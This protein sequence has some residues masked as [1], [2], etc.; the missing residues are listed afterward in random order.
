MLLDAFK[1]P[2][3]R[4]ACGQ[5][6]SL[7]VNLRGELFVWG[8]GSQGQLGLGRIVDAYVP[9][10]V[11]NMTGVFDVSAGDDYSACLVAPHIGGGTSAESPADP[12]YAE[13]GDLWTWGSCEAGKLGHE[14][15]SSGFCVAPKKV[16]MSVPISKISC[17]TLLLRF[18]KP[19]VYYI[20]FSLW[21]AKAETI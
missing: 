12:V 11:L 20:L 10:G 4:I 3:R 2:I 16:K 14:G 13:A 19:L 1:D 18:R 8:D 5:Q 7:A 17:G 15:L 6:H 9:T 21:C